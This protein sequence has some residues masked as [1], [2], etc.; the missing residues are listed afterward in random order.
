[1]TGLTF[2]SKGKRYDLFDYLSL[3]RVSGL[4]VLKDGKIAF[5]D[6]ELGNTDQTRWVSWSIVKSIS[7]TLVGAAI[8]DRYIGSL[9]DKVTK[10]LPQLAGSAYDGVT[11]KN[12]LQMASGV[13]WNETYTD[14]ESDRRH[15]L[16]LQIQQ[17]SGAILKFMAGLPRAAAPGTVWNYSTGETHVI[18]ALLGAAVKRPL[19]QYL[20]KRSGRILEW[21]QTHLVARGPRWF[22]GRRQQSERYLA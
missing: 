3:N 19:A 4:L 8:Q 14:P 6:Y 2:V 20:L 21:K 16:D 18:G 7:S 10:Y 15:M 12:V 17:K 9:D 1:M 22:G 13:K 5:E 11:I